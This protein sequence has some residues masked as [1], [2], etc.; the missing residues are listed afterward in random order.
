MRLACFLP[1]LLACGVCAARG[2]QPDA[3]RA[4]VAAL[5]AVEHARTPVSLEPLLAAAEAA[6][7]ALMRLHDG[8]RAVIEVYSNAEFARLKAK[9]RGLQLSRG[10]DVYAQPD[11]AWLLQ[12]AQAHGLPQDQE[13]FRLYR[14]YW[15]AEQVPR[16]LSLGQRATPCVRFGEGIMPDVYLEWRNY[17]ARYPGAYVAFTR[18][19]LS[20]LE[21]AEALGV[22]SC[23]DE[24]SVMRELGGFMQRFPQSPVAEK[25]RARLVELKE[26]P[27]LR[28]VHC[29]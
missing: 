5:A 18:Q 20:D 17:A 3:V 10:Y 19:V 13:F 14:A 6:Q 8:D 27:Y 15:T 28:P 4:Y 2:P 21:E 24:D 25:V 12:L 9:L 11:G 26:Q 16:Y 23:G 22:C 1:L 7:D 29:R